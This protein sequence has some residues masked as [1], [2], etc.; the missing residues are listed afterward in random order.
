[1]AI[2]AADP[3]PD[4]DL[5]FLGHPDPGKYRIRILYLQKD[6]VILIFSLFKLSKVQFA[7]KN[8]FILKENAIK[9]SFSFK[10]ISKKD[11][12]PVV[13]GNPDPDPNF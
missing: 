6:P 9:R 13:L 5:V 1:M 7:Q 3:D 2:S 4:P 8:F 12:D 10:Y 11:P